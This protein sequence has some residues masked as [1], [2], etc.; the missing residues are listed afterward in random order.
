MGCDYYTWIETVIEWKDLSGNIR[1]YT[2][3]PG[4]EQY[5]RHYIWNDSIYDADFD[6]PPESDEL[7]EM[8][9]NYGV[10]VLYENGNWKCKEAG[11]NRIMYI[12]KYINISPESLIKVCKKMNGYWR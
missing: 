4:F 10:K 3:K 1:K 12:L 8:I 11:K 9:F 5:E 6:D 7:E 2:D